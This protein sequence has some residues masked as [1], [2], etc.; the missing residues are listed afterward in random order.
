[1][2]DFYPDMDNMTREQLESY[3]A[4]LLQ[5]LVELDSQEPE[6]MEDPSYED[7]A[8]E[9]EELEDLLDELQDLLEN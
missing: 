4:A 8:D 5:K 9:H 3:R 1:M 6:D 2:L 7:W